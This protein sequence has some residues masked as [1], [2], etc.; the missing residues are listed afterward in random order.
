MFP[1]FGPTGAG[2]S[3]LLGFV[4]GQF[5][6]YEN[7]RVTVFDKGRS[8]YVLTAGV[9]GQHYDLGADTSAIGLCPLAFLD[10]DADVAWAG[11]WLAVIYELQTGQAPAPQQREEIHRALQLMQ[12]QPLGRTLTDFR[13]TVQDQAV[14]AALSP[15]TITGPLGRLLDSETDALADGRFTV[16]E[17]EEI[18]GMGPKNLIPV[19]LYLFRRFEKSLDGAPAL[20]LLDEAWVMLGHPV[21]REKIREWLKVLRKANCAV[22]L[23]TQSLSDATA[24]GILDVLLESCPTRILTPNEEAR[25]RGTGAVLG[26]RDFY[27][28][29]G[30]N[31]A[32]LDIIATAVK[33]KHY[34]YVSPEGCRLFELGLGPLALSFVGVSSKEHIAQVRA[35]QA[36]HGPAWRR[37]WLESRDVDYAWLESRE[38]GDAGFDLGQ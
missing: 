3:T 10:T 18:M 6:R 12:Q 22:V 24:S 32:Q 35:L 23:A 28:V 19:L 34:Y 29:L 20:L 30:L 7:A 16:F 5:R 31:D 33:K 11:E 8:T 4:A 14:R 13:T 9:D 21:F 25:K 27:T 17:I 37:F 1:M 36:E 15:Y 26:P 2:K 38:I